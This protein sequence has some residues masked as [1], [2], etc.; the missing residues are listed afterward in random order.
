MV[1]ATVGHGGSEGGTGKEAE[2]TTKAR[3]QAED[4]GLWGWG[5]GRSSASWP[6]GK[7]FAKGQ[8]AWVDMGRSSYREPSR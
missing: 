5:A 8:T 3:A 2:A 4:D 1:E 7:D 6:A